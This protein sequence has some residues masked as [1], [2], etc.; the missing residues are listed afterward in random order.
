MNGNKSKF[1]LA[2]DKLRELIQRLHEEVSANEPPDVEKLFQEGVQTRI[3]QRAAYG[4]LV[5]FGER[6]DQY[7]DAMLDVYKAT[8]PKAERISFGAAESATQLAILKALDP[9][10]KQATLGFSQRLETAI[11]ELRKTLREQPAG[12]IVQMEVAGLL[13]DGLPRTIG[14][15][16]FYVMDH[17]RLSILQAH[18]AKS[19]DSTCSPVAVKDE[20]KRT[21]VEHTSQVWLGK[22]CADVR[23][24]ASEPEAANV[25]AVQRLR[26]TMD[27]V[28]FFAGILVSTDARLYLPWEANPHI[29]NSLTFTNDREQGNLGRCWRGPWIPLSLGQMAS[30][31]ADKAGFS[32]AST[33]LAKA[34][35]NTLENRLLSAMRWAGRASVEDRREEAFLLFVVSLESLLLDNQDNQQL[36]Y[37]FGI[38]GAHLLGTT[39]KA[40]TDINKKLKDIYD[41]RSAVVHSGS[42]EIT[43]ANRDTVHYFARRALYRVLV[44]KPFT[45]MATEAELDQWFEKQIL[46]SD[47]TEPRA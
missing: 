44:T 23:V 35:P 28:N 31:R 9:L 22:I 38:R 14:D 29:A 24:F 39:L 27:V 17:N 21:V 40:K 25:L 10:K 34:N 1:D 19:I 5:L 12:W 30:P 47:S 43:D 20:A 2:L 4:S 8:D 42:T 33:I 6:S 37:R 16:E 26:L 32:K 46:G 11:A 18:V 36:R 7:R 45:D 15:T 41:L 3:F 13:P